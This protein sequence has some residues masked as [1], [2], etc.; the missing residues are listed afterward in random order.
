MIFM[1]NT[2]LK[3]EFKRSYKSFLIWSSI[4]VATLIIFTVI[5]PL[6]ADI[7]EI[8]PPQLEVI[9]DAW[10]GKPDN[11]LEYFSIE[12]ASMYF[13]VGP[14][15]AS[16]LGFT[17]VST[18]ERE[19]SAEVLYTTRVDKKYFYISKIIVLFVLL[20]LF[21][22]INFLASY[23]TMLFFD[24]NTEVVI[25]ALYFLMMNITFIV[26]G[27]MSFTIALLT[28]PGTNPLISMTLPIIFIIISYISKLSDN[29]IITNLK[30]LTPLAF[31]DATTI[32]ME[33][34]GVEWLNLTIFT[35]ISV[36]LLIFNYY[37]FQKRVS[38]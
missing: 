32:I 38:I 3:M 5:Y 36:G 9:M 21:S 19:K 8:L 6:Y 7:F 12:T 2:L 23:I 27:I 31:S 30:Y 1:L 13:M 11:I 29:T 14:I 37:K 10:G 35:A 17:L 33:K 16:M 18:F 34:S 26:I 15:Y 25:L 28:K 24:T 4:M 22:L 20:T